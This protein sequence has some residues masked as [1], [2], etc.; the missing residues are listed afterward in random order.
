MSDRR[1]TEDRWFEW[2]SDSDRPCARCVQWLTA[3]GGEPI[4]VDAHGPVRL[5][6]FRNHG[7]CVRRDAAERAADAVRSSGIPTSSRAAQARTAKR[8]ND[9]ARVARRKRRAANAIGRSAK[10]RRLAIR[11]VG[12][13]SG[14]RSLL[15]SWYDAVPTW[16]RV[17]S[18]ALILI[19]G[20]R[21]GAEFGVDV[22]TP[23]SV[24]AGCVGV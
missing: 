16:Y 7:L 24:E 11:N 23:Q 17:G 20:L 13:Q 1:T 5:V 22:S 8:L 14:L 10:A 12:Q 19:R 2:S 21:H 9:L 4:P 6:Y 3:D 15:R 18:L